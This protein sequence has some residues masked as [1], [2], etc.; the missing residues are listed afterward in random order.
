MIRAIVR[1]LAVCR[2]RTRARLFF[3]RSLSQKR[4]THGSLCLRRYLLVHRPYQYVC[5]YQPQIDMTGNCSQSYSV[6]SYV[7]TT[8]L[9]QSIT[10][11]SDKSHHPP[12]TVQISRDRYIRRSQTPQKYCCIRTRMICTIYSSS[13]V[14]LQVLL[15]YTGCI[16][17]NIKYI[18]AKNILLRI[19]VHTWQ[20][21][22]RTYLVESTV[23]TV[24]DLTNMCLQC[25]YE[26][27]I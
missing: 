12:F 17:H 22:T 21:Y 27:C 24:D 2:R 18:T 10:L 15:L 14:L 8:Q 6:Q 23:I 4:S 5:A 25:D 3:L 26:Y 1:P 19:L 20:K 9:V 16:F 7:R 13:D 11:T